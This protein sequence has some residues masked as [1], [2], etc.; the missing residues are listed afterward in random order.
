MSLAAA[1]IALG[2]NKGDRLKHMSTAL[3]LL[4]SEARVK[5]LCVSPLYQNRAVGMGDADDFYNA[6]AK[7]ETVLGPE[8]LLDRCLSI[9]LELGRE[10]SREG[11]VPRTIDLDLLLYGE[12]RIDTNRLTLPHPR[13]AERDF[14]AVPLFDL[15]PDLDVSGKSIR[16][17]IDSLERI[18]LTKMEECLR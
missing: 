11:W 4:E 12:E 1:Y 16:L 7:V 8:A 2:S 13:I 9:E 15:E 18:E 14:V 5:V 10:R 3:D 6:V 17:I